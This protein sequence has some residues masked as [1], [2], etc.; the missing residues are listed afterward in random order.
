MAGNHDGATG[1]SGANSPGP[2]AAR[3]GTGLP[4]TPAVPLPG[5]FATAGPWCGG[6]ATASG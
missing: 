6:T 4:E 5:A 2:D 3:A 1:T